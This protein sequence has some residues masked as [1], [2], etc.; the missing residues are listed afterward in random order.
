[1][2]GNEEGKDLM[3]NNRKTKAKLAALAFSSLAALLLPC[4]VMAGTDRWTPIGPDGGGVSALA[5]NPNTPSTLYAG[6]NT[7]G[8]FKSTDRGSTWSPAS[9][10][11]T[12]SAVAALAIDP[13]SS[14]NI[15]AGS[16]HAA[17]DGLATAMDE[18]KAALEAEM[19]AYGLVQAEKINWFDGYKLNHRTPRR[20]TTKT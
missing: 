2:E 20:C 7:A 18:H 12:F 14:S 6:T 8:V 19:Q 4:T 15:Y 10:G 3:E 5:I 1:M 9:V 11:L 13:Q 16:I 17:M